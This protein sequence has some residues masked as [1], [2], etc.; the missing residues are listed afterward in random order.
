MPSRIIKIL[1]SEDKEYQDKIKALELAGKL[2]LRFNDEDYKSI[3]DWMAAQIF[4]DKINEE[5]KMAIT[6]LF[7]YL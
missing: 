6:Q 3:K 4:S 1:Q 2:S 7:H 5:D